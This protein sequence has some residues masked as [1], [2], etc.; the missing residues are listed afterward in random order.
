MVSHKPRGVKYG[1]P[2]TQ[3]AQRGLNDVVGQYRDT[4]VRHRRSVLDSNTTVGMQL[5]P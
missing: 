3:E 4:L 2:R 1:A 5:V